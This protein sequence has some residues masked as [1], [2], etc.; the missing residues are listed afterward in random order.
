[1]ENNIVFGKTFG[2]QSIFSAKKPLG[3][4]YGKKLNNNNTAYYAKKGEPMYMKEMDADEDGV[5][6]IDEFKYY[7][8]ANNISPKEMLRMLEM[9]NAYRT[10]QAQ[11]KASNKIESS[12]KSDD[13]DDEAVYAKKGDAKYDE[14]MDANSD[15][16]IT[17]KEYVE[18][19]RENAKPQD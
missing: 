5:V 12:Q 3:L 9:G 6:T 15:D 19:C 14:A 10:M 13:S 4:E 8:Q 1:M 2:L 18:Y 17:Y 7:C 16:K 11:K